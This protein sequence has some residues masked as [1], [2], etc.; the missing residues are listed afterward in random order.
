VQ[1]IE[2]L[3][4]EYHCPDD[5][6][7]E[8]HGDEVANDKEEAG[9]VGPEVESGNGNSCPEMRRRMTIY[10]VKNLGWRGRPH[11][12]HMRASLYLLENK[13]NQE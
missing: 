7:N 10:L 12:N 13:I 11:C 3:G 6:E 1:P 5:S 8:N 9:D 4:D 2:E